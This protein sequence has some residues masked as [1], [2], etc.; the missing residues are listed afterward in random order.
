M[1]LVYFFINEIK[2]RCCFV[3]SDFE[4]DYDLADCSTEM[5]M[6]YELPDG[7]TITIKGTY[8]IKAPELMF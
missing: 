6:D 2:K 4:S 1:Y 5:D 7:E 8:R 3:S